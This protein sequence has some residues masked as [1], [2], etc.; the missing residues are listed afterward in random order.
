MMTDPDGML[1]QNDLDYINGL[2]Y[3]SSSGG[4]TTYSFSNGLYSS[5]TSSFSSMSS[6]E[7]R[8]LYDF[9]MGGG[10]G[11]YTYWT[12]DTMP[13]GNYSYSNG[14]QYRNIQ[15]LIAHQITLTGNQPQL[16]ISHY[17]FGNY[18]S[19]SSGSFDWENSMK[20]VFSVEGGI[21]AY[22]SRNYVLN[23]E[24]LKFNRNG[25]YK[26]S[27][28]LT[29]MKNGQSYWNNNFVKLA[30]ETHLEKLKGIS[31]IGAGLIAADIAM[32]GEIK[33]SH[34]INVLM[35]SISG[36][37]VGAAVGG[38]WFVADM[39]TGAVNYLNGNGFRTLSDVID[40]N[41]GTYKMYDGLY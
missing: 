27:G 22:A 38:L 39:G 4:A 20:W 24:L 1:T 31:K 30:R 16:S 25:A 32:S 6:D 3:G 15:G 21:S 28:L 26:W 12:G 13:S 35:L 8:G 5:Y 7:F 33:P 19:S 29:K 17:N 11:S 10:F 23:N 34:G 37:G 40:D 14:D 9:V 36:T 2:Y 18:S 41:V